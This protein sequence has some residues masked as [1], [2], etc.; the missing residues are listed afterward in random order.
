MNVANNPV[1]ASMKD[2]SLVG[3]IAICN[4]FLLKLTSNKVIIAKNKTSGSRWRVVREGE[5]KLS[6]EKKV[7]RY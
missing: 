2:I 5:I 4:N 1:A 3:I 7:A 6:G